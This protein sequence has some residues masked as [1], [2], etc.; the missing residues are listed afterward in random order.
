VARRVCEKFAQIV[1]QPSFC[2]N[3]CIIFTLGKVA[4]N[5]GLLLFF[6]NL[7]NVSNRPL[8]EN[9]PNLVTLSTT[10]IAANF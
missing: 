8:G 3:Q 7:P 6:L 2:Q 9:S 5:F 10:P 4:Q 1:A